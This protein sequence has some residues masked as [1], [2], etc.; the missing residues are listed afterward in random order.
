MTRVSASADITAVFTRYML[1]AEDIWES[2]RG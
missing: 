1:E 2:S